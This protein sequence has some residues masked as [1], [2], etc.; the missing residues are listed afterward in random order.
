MIT[1]RCRS[2][3]THTYSHLQPVLAQ[4]LHGELSGNN[5]IVT[6]TKGLHG[7]FPSCS[8]TFRVFDD[9]I[10][11]GYVNLHQVRLGYIWFDQVRLELNNCYPNLT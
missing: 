8:Q 5:R 6:Q 9:Q 4:T 3:Q 11:I 7:D 1:G 10:R 2:C